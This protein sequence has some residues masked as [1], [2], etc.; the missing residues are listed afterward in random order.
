MECVE[1][2]MQEMLDVTLSEKFI[3]LMNSAVC[4]FNNIA[5]NFLSLF[6][7]RTENFLS[8]NLLHCMFV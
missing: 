1:K 5:R 4:D 3:C 8:K 6:L 2:E 7:V